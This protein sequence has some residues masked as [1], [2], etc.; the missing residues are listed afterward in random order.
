MNVQ[1]M[2]FLI[3]GKFESSRLS[4]QHV[5][6]SLNPELSNE[7]RFFKFRSLFDDIEPFEVD[8]LPDF[9]SIFQTFRRFFRFLS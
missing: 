3:N 7:T 2:K 8:L 1:E 4:G 9:S 6:E 5:L